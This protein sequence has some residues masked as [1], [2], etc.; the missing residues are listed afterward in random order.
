MEKIKVK[1]VV[2]CHN[3]NGEPELVPVTVACT[4]TEY[5]NNDHYAQARVA[6][7]AL[8]YENPKWVADDRD[9]G[10]VL[11]DPGSCL[12]AIDQTVI[13]GLRARGFAVVIWA[14]EE[15][16]EADARRVQDRL[17]E[18]GHSVIEDLQ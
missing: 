5:I 3:K 8:G 17:V 12:S 13:K 18:L 9:P 14:P 7:S 15:L 6:V 11:L 10:F 2:G 16:G 1:C 4:Q